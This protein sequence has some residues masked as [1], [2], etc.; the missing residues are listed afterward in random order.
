[1]VDPWAK[2]MLNNYFEKIL[3]LLEQRRFWAAIFGASSV[4]LA[5]LGKTE[6]AGVFG[7]LSG[8]FGGWS[9][10]KPKQ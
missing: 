4:C 5:V 9:L 8:A 2:P 1:M 3:W 7:A 10:A 6:L